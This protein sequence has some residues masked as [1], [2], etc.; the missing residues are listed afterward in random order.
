MINSKW[1]CYL[2]L[3][4]ILN[5]YRTTI[6]ISVLLGGHPGFAITGLSQLPRLYISL[7][8]KIIPIWPRMT[9]MTLKWLSKKS[10]SRINPA[11][12][13]SCP[14]PF[15][16]VKRFYLGLPL[17][18]FKNVN[19]ENRT[20]PQSFMSIHQCFS[21]LTM[22]DQKMWAQRIG[23]IPKSRYPTPMFTHITSDDPNYLE[24]TFKIFCIENRPHPSSFISIH[25]Y[26]SP[27]DNPRWPWSDI[28]DQESTPS[29]KFH[30][31]IPI[32]KGFYL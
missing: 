29:T 10:K 21:H 25:Q 28:E 18:T 6:N 15:I 20:H 16:H 4:I 32:V 8:L 2:F 24:V 14:C 11:N 31:Q 13:V 5:V 9:Q 7:D 22:D 26:T 3:C 27:S 12:Q 19:T 23:L 17:I 30:G 1:Y